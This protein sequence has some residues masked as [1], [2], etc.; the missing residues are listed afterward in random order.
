MEQ[1]A[2]LQWPENVLSWFAADVLRFFA[3]I[4]TFSHIVTCKKTQN[5]VLNVYPF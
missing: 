5:K 2:V 3:N 1:N 4:G